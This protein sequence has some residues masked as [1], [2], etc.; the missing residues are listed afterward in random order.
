MN[1]WHK[2][3][4]YSNL[5]QLVKYQ[6]VAPSVCLAHMHW[7]LEQSLLVTRCSS[8]QLKR[9][10]RATT[11]LKNF[12]QKIIDNKREKLIIIKCCPIHHQVRFWFHC[13]LKCKIQANEGALAWSVKLLVKKQRNLLNESFRRKVHLDNIAVHIY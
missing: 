7:S 3:F 11:L 12:I 10:I 9:W 1:T 8:L 4:Y 5:M 13:P 2:L 6:H